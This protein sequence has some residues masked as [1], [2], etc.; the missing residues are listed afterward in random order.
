MGLAVNNDRLCIR[1]GTA[2]IAVAAAVVALLFVAGDWHWHAGFKIKLYFKHPG[3]LREGAAV[4]AGGRVIGKVQTLRL[5][6]KSLT[7]DPQHPLHGAGG[8]VA[9]VRIENRFRNRVPINGQFYVNSKGLLS[10]PYV[11]IG[12]PLEGAEWKR[13]VHD[14]DEIRGSDPPRLDLV[15]RRS[16]ENLMVSARFLSAVKPEWDALRTELKKLGATLDEI[17]PGPVTASQMFSSVSTAIDDA[18]SIDAK[19]KAS[20]VTVDELRTIRSR[21]TTMMAVAQRS[22]DEVRAKL[23]VLRSEVDRVRARIPTGLRARFKLALA[24]TDKSLAKLRKI[25]ATAK[26]LGAMIKRGEGSIGALMNDPEFADDAK[27]LGKMLKS[28]PWRLIGRPLQ[29]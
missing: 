26:E 29:K 11:E 10:K 3:A 15:M 20:G 27:K 4:H 23:R 16:Y 7:K 21:F 14:G 18:K 24:K 13:L 22:V 5:I 12:P 2:V 9:I 6:P 1:V 17:S 25:I 19:L 28:Q 8:V